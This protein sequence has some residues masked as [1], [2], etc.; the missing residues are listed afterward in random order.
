MW[1]NTAAGNI[2]ERHRAKQRSIP[3]RLHLHRGS[4]RSAQ[5][6]FSLI[7][8]MVAVTL[9]ATVMLVSIGSL[10]S[11]VEANRKARA[12]ESVMNNLNIALDGM[13]RAIRMGSTYHCGS[14]NLTQ[15]LDCPSGGSQ[16]AFEPFGGDPGDPD[17]QW[18]YFHDPSTQGL[19]RS[20]RSGS[21]PALIT[22]PQVLIEEMT[23]YVVGTDRGCE[24]S[25]CDMVQ[26]KVVI[27][28]KGT[29]GS[30]RVR[31]RTSFSIQATAVQRLLDI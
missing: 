12:L 5:R 3:A 14:G 27:T 6:G 11:L 7:E 16:I 20:T 9:F 25:P 17:D 15:P 8:L 29:A 30:E 10:L 26:P 23:F 18:V 2:R 19:Y 4:S 21:N 13:V 24:V 31:T 22:S 28:M 1:S